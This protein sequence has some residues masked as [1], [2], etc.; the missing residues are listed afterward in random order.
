MKK[1]IR[2]ADLNIVKQYIVENFTRQ[3]TLEELA[4]I[5]NLNPNYFSALYK[6]TF[7]ISPFDYIAKLRINKA[8]QL[9]L[10]KN[11]RLKTVAE[12][13]GYSDEFYFSRVFKK[14]EGLSPKVYTN[15][16][17]SRIG[18]VTGAMMGYLE[19]LG[20]IPFSAPLSAKWTPYYYNKWSESIEYPIS[21]TDEKS[22][23]DI[24]ELLQV[25]FDLLISPNNLPNDVKIHLSKHFP[26]YWVNVEN[27]LFQELERLAEYVHK[28]EEAKKWINEYEKRKVEISNQLNWTSSPQ[29]F[30]LIRIYHKH[31]YAYCNEGI[32]QVL[33]QDLGAQSSYENT[34]LYNNEISVEQLFNMKIDKLF[35][36]IYA[37]DCSRSTWYQLQKQLYKESF[38]K[39][40]QSIY[41]LHADPWFEHSPIAL[42]RMIEEVAVMFLP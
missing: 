4:K 10:D 35:V 7:S 16:A 30:L 17:K 34:R 8:K 41:I 39:D 19:P 22:Y 13:V 12:E 33:F 18:V 3:L 25:Q 2:K 9:L 40:A 31:L 37:D 29:R 36:I 6:E 23:C 28:K 14:I 32:Y 20:I 1:E 5:A 11:I 42:K 27:S 21:F 24:N 15:T 26:I 38:I